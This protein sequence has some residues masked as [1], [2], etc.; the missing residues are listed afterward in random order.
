MNASFH[1]G[2]RNMRRIAASL[3]AICAS[4]LAL[5]LAGLFFSTFAQKGKPEEYQVKAVYLYNFGRF[6]DWPDTQ[7]KIPEFPICVIGDDP[8]GKTL[9]DVV[10]GDTI[11]NHKLIARRITNVR[12]AADCRIVF[13]SASESTRAKEIV[14]SLAKL[15]VLTV[16][17]L[18]DFIAQ[19]GAIQFVISD[20]RVRFEVNL[21]ATNQAGLVVSSQLLKVAASVKQSSA[22]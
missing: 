18:P 2:R 16:S 9:D 22:K 7:D 3:R 20:N 10:A 13:I 8:F 4:S 14:Q 11:D 19:G 5:L 17:D 21:D 12:A 15:P 6:V 1:A